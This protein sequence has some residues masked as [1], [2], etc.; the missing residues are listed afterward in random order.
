MEVINVLQLLQMLQGFTTPSF[1]RGKDEN[2]KTCVTFVTDYEGITYNL[3]FRG[4]L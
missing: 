4:S 2:T 1:T 3:L